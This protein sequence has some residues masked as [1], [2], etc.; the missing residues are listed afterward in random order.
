MLLAI[1]A[2]ALKGKTSFT[3]W[4]GGVKS[5]LD[6]ETIHC[7]F[8]FCVRDPKALAHYQYVKA[9]TNNTLVVINLIMMKKLTL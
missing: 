3:M 7:R 4:E 2:L 1:A 9:T 6:G 8:T 5:V